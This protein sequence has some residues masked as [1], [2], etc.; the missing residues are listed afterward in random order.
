M[1]YARLGGVPHVRTV[2]VERC[3]GAAGVFSVADGGTMPASKDCW[4]CYHQIV[5]RSC[6]TCS[7]AAP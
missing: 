6:V 4:G 3:R 7:Q 2:S 1:V 5:V